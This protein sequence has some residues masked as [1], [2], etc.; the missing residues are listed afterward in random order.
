MYLGVANSGLLPA[1]DWLRLAHFPCLSWCLSGGKNGSE[2]TSHIAQRMFSSRIGFVRRIAPIGLSSRWLRFHVAPNAT[3]DT[4]GRLSDRRD[5]HAEERARHITHRQYRRIRVVNLRLFRRTRCT[6][7]RIW[8]QISSL[9]GKSPSKSLIESVNTTHY[10]WQTATE[11]ASQA[12]RS[13]GHATKAGGRVGGG[14]PMLPRSARGPASGLSV[15][16][17]CLSS[18]AD[19]IFRR[20]KRLCAGACRAPEADRRRSQPC[21]RSR[22]IACHI[23]LTA[24][25]AD[26]LVGEKA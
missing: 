25:R 7:M 14:P 26:H 21:L 19:R 4:A 18:V 8:R 12:A 16:A 11:Q 1:S 5:C 10:I 20:R 3:F 13:A 22:E 17:C 24:A 9:V 6:N 23:C 15:P 2:V